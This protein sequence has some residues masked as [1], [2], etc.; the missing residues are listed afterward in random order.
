MRRMPHE[1]EKEIIGA[2]SVEDALPALECLLSNG[3]NVWADGKLYFIK[4]CVCRVNGLSLYIYPKDHPPPH[5][6][7]RGGGID[8]GFCIENCCLLQCRIDPRH[9]TLIRWWLQRVKSKLE[10]RWERLSVSSCAT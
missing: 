6:H 1:I 2:E 7:I 3:Y 4:E 10:A 9:Q 5:F 8:A